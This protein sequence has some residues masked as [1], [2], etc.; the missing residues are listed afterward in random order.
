MERYAI[1]A[2]EAMYGGSHGICSFAIVEG[3]EKD[4]E[5]M[6]EEMSLEVRD[7]YSFFYEEFEASAKAEGYEEG[8]DEFDE[9]IQD[10]YDENICYEVKRIKEDVSL[11]DE[12]CEELLA[13]DYKGFFKK[14]CE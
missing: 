6:A 1:Y 9:Y 5:A 14:Y 12:K 11:S 3:S 2:Y 4:A 10:C 8:T 13:D 7:D